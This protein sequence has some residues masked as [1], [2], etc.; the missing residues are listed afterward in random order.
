MSS[1]ERRRG[2]GRSL[3]AI[4]L[5]AALA[6]GLLAGCDNPACVFG[7]DCSQVGGG[8]LGG[9]NPAFAPADDAWIL[10]GA[11]TVTGFFPNGGAIHSET[12][13]VVLFS[14]S[15]AA[16]TVTSNIR[17]FD[18]DSMFGETPV[19]A[20]SFLVG[21][22][23]VL[24]VLPAGAL[25]ADHTYELR[26]NENALVTDLT[27]AALA[28]P[29]DLLI[30]SITVDTTDPV[31][32]R[33]ITSWPQDLSDDQSTT[34]EIV[35][36]F[37][38]SMDETTV[39]LS[40]FEV[41][42][43]GQPPVFNTVAQALSIGVLT[44]DSRVFQYRNTDGSGT[45]AGFGPSAMVNVRLSKTGAKIVADDG[46]VLPETV[47]DFTTASFE[48]PLA[49][50]IVSLPMDAIGIDNLALPTPTLNV[51]VTV[52]AQPSDR[53]GVFLFGQS[54]ANPGQ[55]ETLFRDVEISALSVP[56]DAVNM[57][58]TLTE[59]ELQLA[60]NNALPVDANF[61]DGELT[62]ALR[63]ERAGEFSAVRLLDTDMNLP[64]VQSAVLDVTRPTF[65]A[66]GSSG[67]ETGDFTSDL[68]DLCVVGRADERIRV[69]IVTA[70]AQNNQ[71]LSLLPPVIG[72]DD[73]GLFVAAPVPLGLVDPGS[74][75]VPFTLDLYDRA[76]NRAMA[77]VAGD[78]YQVGS[79]G[80]GALGASFDVD[81]YDRRTLAPIAGASVFVHQVNAGVVTS[82]GPAQ[83]TDGAGR[84]NVGSAPAGDTI[85]TVDALGY[86]LWSFEAVP[87]DRISAPLRRGIDLPGSLSGTI[88]SVITNG[89]FTSYARH[90]ADSRALTLDDATLPAAGCIPNLPALSNECTYGPGAV[91]VG[92][93]RSLSFVAVNHPV[94]LTGANFSALG[95]LKGYFLEAPLAEP[96][97]GNATSFDFRVDVLL[98]DVNLPLEE[99]ALEGP[100]NVPLFAAGI[101][102]I[103]LNNL[104]E[105]EV[106]VR[107]RLSSLHGT[108]LVGYG[109]ALDPMGA[110]AD[111][112]S[113]YT[114]I[115]GV[116]DP[117]VG[118]GEG[119]LLSDG[120]LAAGDMTVRCEVRD[121]TRNRTVHRFSFLTP[122]ASVTPIGVPRITFPPDQGSSGAVGYDLDFAGVLPGGGGLYGATLV[123][124]DGRRWELYRTAVGGATETIHVVDLAAAGGFGLPDGP[125]SALVEAWG[126]GY[127]PTDFLFS[128]VEREYVDYAAGTGVTYTQP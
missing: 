12:P 61:D 43:G 22:G 74:Q 68:R 28:L 65:T 10:T 11:P 3:R 4:G 100:T 128:D 6:A 99:Q 37:D 87:A 90:V 58:A 34:T 31:A 17:L 46:G 102:G 86:D 55:V 85:V 14:E 92:P 73:A 23:R 117:T 109:A 103:D 69:A 101:G 93:V 39:G 59:T 116:A 38:R 49:A 82:L 36:I 118:P 54:K 110:P 30:G 78:F 81:V 24:V 97:P 79:M 57:L 88:S 9:N 95:F 19:P 42:V 114:A 2:P 76:L 26:W 64:L 63:L 115:P 119:E 29:P 62:I 108:A 123:G 47:F 127:D 48:A 15:M 45:V 104:E 41:T 50:E 113:V 13:L 20:P 72:S 8:A 126:W 70:G 40:S 106:S 120:I 105:P 44:T 111:T 56:Y 94:T 96:V 89:N 75:P 107:A 16:S 77:P 52:E 18:L 21:N 53:L 60:A 66:F 35:A 125:V 98:D 1:T 51:A 33:V 84:V 5:A 27:G 121:T 25:T 32:P 67:V 71:S 122:P 112:W 124:A 80:A 7:G 83:L 91:R